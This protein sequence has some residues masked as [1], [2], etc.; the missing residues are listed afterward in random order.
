MERGGRSAGAA[1]RALLACGV[2]AALASC[3]GT[4][5]P[6]ELEL[7]P[8]P[9]VFPV[10]DVDP[11][12]FTHEDEQ[13][14]TVEVLYATDR[15]PSGEEE[16]QPYYA[17]RRGWELRLGVAQVRFGD[18]GETWESL[19]ERSV[20]LE[21]EEPVPVVVEGV[22]DFGL[23]DTTLVDIEGDEFAE[24]DQ[25]AAEAMFIERVNAKLARS[26]NEEIVIFVHGYKVVYENPILVASQLWHYMGYD[27]VMIPYSWPSTPAWWAY[28]ADLETAKSSAR[29]FRMF[30][31]FLSENTSAKRIHV[32]GYSAGTQ[33]VA[34]ALYELA[35]IHDEYSVEEIRDKLRIGRVILAA[36]DLELGVFLTMVDEG[37]LRIPR[38]LTLYASPK[39]SALGFARFFL[40]KDRVGLWSPDQEIEPETIE[41]LESH[42]T[43][44]IINVLGAEGIEDGNGHGYF[45]SSPWASSDILITLSTDRGPG[46]RGLDRLEHAPIWLFPPDYLDV[47]AIL[48]EEARAQL[49]AEE[50]EEQRLEAEAATATP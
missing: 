14:T 6:Y 48:V 44:E 10:C 29:N 12:R 11:F 47:L 18:P 32:V 3:K 8:A 46:E 22:Q 35:L 40:R 37:L 7:M 15:E 30:L 41:F 28:F 17:N 34:H 5:Y 26:V 23:L 21:R 9:A 38:T 19:V 2:L 24:A 20:Q 50:L 31:Q 16:K 36:S 13:Q 25:D 1:T 45:Q 4:S 43:L 42:P 33:V 49:A 39:D 27:G